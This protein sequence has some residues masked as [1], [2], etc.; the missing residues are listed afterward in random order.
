MT[1]DKSSQQH[2][3]THRARGR[4]LSHSASEILVR[5]FPPLISD[6]PPARGGEDKGPSPLEYVLAAL[7][8]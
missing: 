6:E 4:M 1:G 3:V 7:C 5:Q 2:V 8:A